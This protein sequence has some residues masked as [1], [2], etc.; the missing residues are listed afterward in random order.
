MLLAALLSSHV[1]GEDEQTSKKKASRKMD[2]IINETQC[3]S[4]LGK[5]NR[6][7]S[8]LVAFFFFFLKVTNLMLA[9]KGDSVFFYPLPYFK[10]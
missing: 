10:R 7:S 1:L 4:F 8:L 9:S 6:G 3:L 2:N 5:E